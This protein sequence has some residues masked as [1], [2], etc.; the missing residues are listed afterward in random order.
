MYWNCATCVSLLITK[1]EYIKLS[2]S[3]RENSW[4]RNVLSDIGYKQNE[5][6]RIFQANNGSIIWAADTAKFKNNKHIDV[7]LHHI[8]DL[9]TIGQIKIETVDT[10][11]IM[12]DFLAKQL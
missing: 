9:M 10:R 4:L 7:R 11:N 1:A 12:G 6:M 8:R 2:R 3:G 5:P